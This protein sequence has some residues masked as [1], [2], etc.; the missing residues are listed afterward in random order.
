MENVRKRAREM[1][2]FNT[3]AKEFVYVTLLHL[4]PKRNPQSNEIY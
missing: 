4:G 2:I 3:A 1:G